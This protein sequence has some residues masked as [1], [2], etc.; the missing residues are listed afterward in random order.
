MAANPFIHHMRPG[1]TFACGGYIMLGQEAHSPVV[2]TLWWARRH[3][4]LW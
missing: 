4:R 1:G 3:T 2:G